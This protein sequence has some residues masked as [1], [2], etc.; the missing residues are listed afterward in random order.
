MR[1]IYPLGLIIF[2]LRGNMCH[3][4]VLLFSTTWKGDFK[5]LVLRYRLFWIGEEREVNIVKEKEHGRTSAL[6]SHN[7]DKVAGRRYHI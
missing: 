7:S 2:S 1:R 5:K 3:H 4:I 6:F